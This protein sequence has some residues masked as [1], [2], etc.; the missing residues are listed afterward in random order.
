M[1]G[2]T[3]IQGEEPPLGPLAG[4]RVVDLTSVV[5][6]PYATQIMA[7]MGAEVIK[8]EP[9]AG[10]NTRWITEGPVPGMGGI[11]VNVNRGKR[12]LMLDL[13]TETDRETLRRLIATADVFIHSMR[14]SAIA[15][16]GFDYEA[17]R[18]IRPDIIYTNCYGYSRRGPE[19]DR[20]A[21]DDTIQAE[22]GIPH[23]QGL[24]NGEPGY[25]AT[26]MADKVAGLHA[27]YATM[28]ALFHRERTGGRG[29]G[30]GQEVEVTMFEAMTSF[31]LVEHAN[32]AMF[33]PPTTPAHYHR[34]VEP[35]RR[36]YRTRDGHVAA[37]VYND[38]H[39]DAFMA[40]VNPPWASEE[41]STLAKRAKQIGRVYGLLGETFLTRTTQEWLETLE[42]LHIPCA[43][44]RSTD[45]LFDNAHLNAIG[46]FEEVETP[47]GPVRFPGVPTWF[48][49]TPGK[50]RGP[51][52]A[53]GQD[54]EAVLKEL[55]PEAPSVAGA[56]AVDSK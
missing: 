12:G 17:V 33:S 26:I 6:G 14:G 21:Y 45:A 54:N 37:L 24:M 8:I 16:L 35:N 46:F 42:A 48:S 20:P 36:P 55:A 15:K 19:G 3:G 56:I 29:A 5:F 32:G 40:A 10:D 51:A 2:E 9:P 4:I 49:A 1:A 47:Q 38:K 27:L 44:L 41:F 52:P 31:M 34:A 25:V 50:V 22:C 28:M 11:Y 53:L 7:D 23:V 30:E 39:W 13:R 18:A 43:P